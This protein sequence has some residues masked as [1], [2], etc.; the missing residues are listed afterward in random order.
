MD[1][2]Q[3]DLITYFTANGVKKTHLMLFLRE[4][5]SGKQEITNV[6]FYEK[7]KNANRLFPIISKMIIISKF[8]SHS[9]T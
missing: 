6:A 3:V 1:T 7:I 8:I 4:R 5:L 2:L 9:K